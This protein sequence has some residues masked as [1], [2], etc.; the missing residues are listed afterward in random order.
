ML[1]LNRQ[2]D[3]P[4]DRLEKGHNDEG[5]E[6]SYGYGDDREG[7]LHVEQKRHQYEQ[8]HAVEQRVE[9][10]SGQELAYAIDLAQTAYRFAGL[11]SLEEV[12]W[13]REQ[14]AEDVQIEPRIQPGDST[15]TSSRRAQ[16]SRASKNIS[17]PRMNVRT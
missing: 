13:Q 3:K 16:P 6:A 17:V 11:T 7:R 8:R 10:L 14:T 1:G 2:G 4:A 12:E 15:S 9:Q 5:D